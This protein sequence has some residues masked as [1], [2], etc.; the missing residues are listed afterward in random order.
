MLIFF[1]KREREREGELSTFSVLSYQIGK[2]IFTVKKVVPWH[3]LIMKPLTD[4][5]V[6]FIPML[7]LCDPMTYVAD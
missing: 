2:I 5:Y 4:K 1:K 6:N 7:P 3:F